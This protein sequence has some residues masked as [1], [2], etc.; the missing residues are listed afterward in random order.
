VAGD[1]APSWVDAELIAQLDPSIADRLLALH[2][3]DGRCP[4]CGAAAPCPAR[5]LAEAVAG[6]AARKRSSSRW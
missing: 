1:D 5:A 6:A 2:P 4:S 3:A